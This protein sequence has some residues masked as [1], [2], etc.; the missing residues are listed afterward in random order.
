M[1]IGPEV[2]TH[3]MNTSGN[4]MFGKAVKP[5]NGLVLF[6]KNTDLTP[7]GGIIGKVG[8]RKKK[9]SVFVDR[10]CVGCCKGLTQIRKESGVFK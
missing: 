10:H 5:G 7:V 3:W 9:A 2:N 8:Y 6:I 1:T 4:R